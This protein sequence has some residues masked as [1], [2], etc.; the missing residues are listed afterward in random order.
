VQGVVKLPY[1]VYHVAGGGECSWAEFAEAIFDEAGIDC[2]VRRIP[3]SEYPLP[4]ERPAYSVLRSEKGA[5]ELPD[6]RDGLR[7]CIA[8]MGRPSA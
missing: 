6:W 8:R 4:A 7:E 5:P 1:G 3:S 2:R